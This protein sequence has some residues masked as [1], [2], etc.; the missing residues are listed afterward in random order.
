MRRRAFLSS[1]AGLTLS[2]MATPPIHTAPRPLI[3]AHRGASGLR[4]EHTLEGY[5]LAADLG[6]DVIEP[7][8]VFTKDGHLICRHDR[9]LSGSTNVAD[10]PAFAGRKTQKAGHDG[11][12]WFAEDFTVDEIKSLRAR[13][14][15]EG[16]STAFDDQFEIPTFAELLALAKAQG[17]RL[18]PEAK[19]PAAARAHGHDFMAALQPFF[20]AA[21]AG[22]IGPSFLQCFDAD[23]LRPIGPLANIQR[24]QLLDMPLPGA[25]R[26]IAA[27]ADGVGPSK[28]ALFQASP[29]L[30]STG[31]VEEAHRLGLTV[32]PWTFRSDALSAPFETAAAEYAYFYRLGVDGVFTDFTAEAVKARAQQ[33]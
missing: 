18:Y 29:Q 26:D 8:L 22:Q 11:P 3:I 12:D 2:A 23:F 9:Y 7:D 4:P 15:F 30:A 27:Y 24:I 32:H 13:Q 21:A 10:I 6:A 16:R 17:W 25:L 33:L 20:K 31:F 19:D 14:P 1:A 5:A 28:Q